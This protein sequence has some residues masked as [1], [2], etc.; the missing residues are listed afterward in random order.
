MDLAEGDVSAKSVGVW[1]AFATSALTL[2]TFAAAVATPPLSGP[3]CRA[4]DCLAYPYLDAISR[5]PRDY[6]WMYP[7]ILLTLAYVSLVAFAYAIAPAHRTFPALLASIAAS[8]AGAFLIADY[9]VQIAVVQP[10]LLAGEADGISLLS[11]YN[12]HGVFIALEELGYLFMALSFLLVAP[13]FVGNTRLER[14]LRIVLRGG[15]VAGIIAFLAISMRYGVHREYRFEV[16]IISI[17]W[18]ALGIASFMMGLVWRRAK[19]ATM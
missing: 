10:S 15:C 9:F 12:P 18:L 4:A 19:Q 17:D 13:M 16:A 11:Q 6:L 7:A 2:L 5:F 3:F 8:L 1:I 14:A